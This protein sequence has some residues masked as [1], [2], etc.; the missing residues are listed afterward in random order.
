[1]DDIWG[2]AK[3]ILGMVAPT[4][5]TAL[6]GPLAGMAV[7]AVSGALLGRDDGT[8]E[9]VA[10]AIQGATPEQMVALKKAD[11]D[12]KVQ[13][14]SLDVDLERIAAG[15]RDSARKREVDTGDVWTPRV[16]ASITIGGFLGATYMVL[17]GAVEGLKDPV[18]SVLIGT[19]IGYV[20]AKADQVVG[21]YFGSPAS[22]A[23]KTDA[24][25]SALRDKIDG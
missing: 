1:M 17:S 5:A 22:S 20:S 7:K 15:D 10:A 6:G 21:Y 11:T 3:D 8:P 4:V 13:L 24:M 14:K 23:R 25:E 18:A 19:I 2:K 9:E 12:L 16:L